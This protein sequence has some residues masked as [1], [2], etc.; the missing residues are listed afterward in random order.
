M[1]VLW[2]LDEDRERALKNLM[3]EK[4]RER[5]CDVLRISEAN[6]DE[7]NSIGLLADVQ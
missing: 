1:N 3:Y 5:M 7:V 4:I 6:P 2:R